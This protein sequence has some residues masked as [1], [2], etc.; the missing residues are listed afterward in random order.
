M[1]TARPMP[2]EPPVIN[3]YFCFVF[4]SSINS[5]AN[6]YC[7]L[8]TFLFRSINECF[9]ILVPF[10]Q[11]LSFFIYKTPFLVFLNTGKAI[12]KTFIGAALQKAKHSNG[13]IIFHWNNELPGFVNKTPKLFLFYGRQPVV[14]KNFGI[15]VH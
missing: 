5:Q 2:R 6:F 14:R 15:P 11:N 8:N 9:G 7:K 4:F 3:A 10:A 12:D 1:Q 13:N